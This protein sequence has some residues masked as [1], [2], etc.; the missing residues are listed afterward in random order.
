MTD[1]DL[2]T[3]PTPDDV[4]ERAR[5]ALTLLEAIVADR[6]L[7]ADVPEADRHRLLNAAGK[8]FA[9]DA[10]ARRK[11]VREVN[12]RRKA[13]AVEREEKVLRETGIRALRRQTI[14]TTPNVFPPSDFAQQDVDDDPDF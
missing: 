3:T 13:E 8:V 10:S 12:R 14:F 1:P 4:A 5:E 2:P 7:L 9:P 11:F 6:T